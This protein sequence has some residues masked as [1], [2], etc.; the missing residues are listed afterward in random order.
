[1]TAEASKLELC[2]G[3]V[4]EP[5]LPSDPMY[6]FYDGLSRLSSLL[7]KNGNLIKAAG[8]ALIGTHAAEKTGLQL[9]KVFGFLG[10]GFFIYR[11]LI[12]SDSKARARLNDT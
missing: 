10:T 7:G 5:V 8:S 3:G 6:P 4:V 9:F 12:D 11:H 2:K 1:M